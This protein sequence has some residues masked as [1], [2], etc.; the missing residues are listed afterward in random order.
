M[1][2][3]LKHQN[4]FGILVLFCAFLVVLFDNFFAELFWLF[5]YSIWLLLYVEMKKD[6][7]L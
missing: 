6:K 1:N 2:F 7:F 3:K 5:C 4:I